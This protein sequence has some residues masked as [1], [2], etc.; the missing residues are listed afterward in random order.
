MI[1]NH[2]AQAP[3]TDLETIKRIQ[4]LDPIKKPEH[5]KSADDPAPVDD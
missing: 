5:A 3:P 2:F 4:E 1:W